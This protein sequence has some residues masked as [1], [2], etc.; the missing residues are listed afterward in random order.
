MKRFLT[1]LALSL[2]CIFCAIGFTAC[3]ESN[4]TGSN[5]KD[6]ET[7]AIKIAGL[8]EFNGLQ[9]F[10]LDDFVFTLTYSSYEFFEEG[11]VNAK[12]IGATFS[13][14]YVERSGMARYNTTKINE[15]Y[16]R[17]DLFVLETQKTATIYY[18][19]LSIND[20]DITL[21]LSGPN[22]FYKLEGTVAMV[23]YGV[24]V[25]YFEGVSD[26][27]FGKI[28]GEKTQYVYKGGNT[29]NVTAYANNGFQ[30]VGWSDGGTFTIRSE[31][32][33]KT[34]MKINALFRQVHD[35]YKME[36]NANEGGQLEGNNLQ[37]VLGGESA[38]YITAIPYSA[39]LFTG[40]SDGVTTATRSDLANNNLSVTANFDY[41]YTINYSG[42]PTE[43]KKYGIKDGTVDSVTAEQISGYKFIRWSDGVTTET[44]QDVIN[45]NLIN[46]NL[47]DWTTRTI[48]I[49]A[50]Y[51]KVKTLSYVI[52]PA[53]SG[54][55]EG[56]ATQSLYEGQSG[57]E[58]TAVA[59]QGYRFSHWERSST[60][61]SEN[62]TRTDT[63]VNIDLTYYAIFERVCYLN[64][65]AEEGGYINGATE[66]V[67]LYGE[68]HPENVQAVAYEG[69]EFI[70]W[71]DGITSPYRYDDKPTTDIKV[72]ARFRNI[73][74]EIPDN[75]EPQDENGENNLSENFINGSGTQ[76]D[77]YEIS[78]LAML[79][80]IV[81]YPDSYFV[82]TKDI[83][84]TEVSSSG[85]SNFTP[86]FSDDNMFNGT[87]D[88]NGYAI[89]NLTIYNENTFYSGLFAC[90]GNN[91]IVKNLKLTNLNVSGTNYVGGIAGYSL[92]KIID[93]ETQ[94]KITYISANTYKV[95]IGGIAGRTENDINGNKSD[96]EIIVQDFGG[97]S[98]IGGITGYLNYNGTVSVSYINNITA[99]G[100][101]SCS[102]GGLVGF[103][104]SSSGYT[105][106]ENS[107][108]NGNISI[109]S[110]GECNVGGFAG[111]SYIQSKNS[112]ITGNIVANS[113]S[114]YCYAGGLVGYGSV[115]S[116]D[117]YFTGDI[118][119][120]SGAGAYTYAGGFV[121][122][123][124]YHNMQIT[125]SY[126]AGNITALNRY[127]ASIGGFVGK[128]DAA[129]T[130]SYANV[131][132]TATISGG[133]YRNNYVGGFI[134]Y[135]GNA[136]IKNSFT[137]C[138]IDTENGNI[139]GVIGYC[140]TFSLTNAHWL[141]YQDTNN[142]AVGFSDSL[143]I[144]TSIGA[145]AHDS[146]E[147]F[148]TL[149]AKLN[150]GLE[151][152]VWQ[153]ET[154]KDYPTLIQKQK[155]Q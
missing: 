10:V 112:F 60:P 31:T 100:T 63:M 119:A 145:T 11:L 143:G 148:K 43:V 129:I 16:Y 91:G 51:E 68:G 18:E 23:Q 33:V 26:I 98:Y 114:G 27:P 134:G 103:N 150:E 123:N 80:N 54:H 109:T 88:G 117:C 52:W 8:Y 44:R 67:V 141:K 135:C 38:T 115:Q 47:Y 78:S 45:D 132:I 126:V 24:Q 120:S 64:Y 139:G 116:S 4:N 1:I 32:D 146:A 79:N 138:K 9:T 106:F 102:A 86:L 19:G 15:N 75:G 137:L 65:H 29:T 2:L 73:S 25:E 6:N 35:V 76:E 40:W 136:N 104:E 124:N 152:P 81:N 121:G 144:P 3:G 108:V 118:S 111:T 7:D 28:D 66:Q 14:D 70:G 21:N 92:G 133:N 125:N 89:Q 56:N 34:N 99:T 110:S 113:T 93:C 140:N 131:E 128:G 30:F 12:Y 122:D 154:D 147:D 57:T 127:Y 149:A 151:T 96:T 87:F 142:Y 155:E 37:Y 90:I 49:S 22:M 59:E 83:T 85:Q 107:F 77:P 48:D 42:M 58:V 46:Y 50:V 72:T 13:G 39:Y 20:G 82:L 36:Y 130:N 41:K 105:L 55:I 61:I 53:N 69:Y 74:G 94:G 5:N 62:P 17:V 95:F 97:Q 71:S 153:N 84:L 101:S